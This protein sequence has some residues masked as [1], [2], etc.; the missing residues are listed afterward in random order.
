MRVHGHMLQA[1][2]HMCVL[3]YIH[4]YMLRVCSMLGWG[5]HFMILSV[6][7]I[8]EFMHKQELFA[9]EGSPPMRFLSTL[10]EMT[11]IDATCRQLHRPN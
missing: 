11:N 8:S 4:T 6:T 2:E 3:M 9:L 7:R 10:L 1:H 5:E